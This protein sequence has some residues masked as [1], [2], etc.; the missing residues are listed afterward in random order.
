[1]VSMHENYNVCSCFV[2][3]FSNTAAC[4]LFCCGICELRC[5]CACC[6]GLSWFPNNVFM[7]LLFWWCC[8]T[9]I[10]QVSPRVYWYELSP[11]QGVGL[12]RVALK[13]EGRVCHV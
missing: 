9:N 8:I 10:S 7:M 4:A 11:P 2:T 6:F 12:V 1:M 5:L 3:T 13:A